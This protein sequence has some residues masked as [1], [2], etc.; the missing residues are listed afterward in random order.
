MDVVVTTPSG[1]AGA[2][3]G[4]Y[5]YGT[6]P[7]VT[8]ISPPT[9]PI[10]GGTSV[11]ITGLNFTGATS[12]TIGGSPAVIGTVAATTITA[13]TPAHAAGQADV[14][15]TTPI[16]TGTGTKL[17]TYVS[18]LTITSTAAA[19]QKV[20]QTYS[21]QNTA[22][23]GAPGYTYAVT[24]T[25]PPGTSLSAATG[26]VFGIPTALGSFT[27]TITA[28]D[29]IGQTASVNVTA[30]ITG[31]VSQLAL[32]SSVNPSFLGQQ[33]TL[34]ATATP[35]SCTGTIT[36]TD[37]TT[38]T[39][40]C[41]A[42]PIVSGFATCTVKFTTP[43]AHQIQA[44]Y[45]GSAQCLAS[46]SPVLVQTVNDQTIKTTQTIGNF[47][48][49]RNDLIMSSEPDLNRQVDRLA[50]ADGEFVGSTPPGAPAFAGVAARLGGGPDA[51]DLSRMRFGLRDRPGAALPDSFSSPTSGLG[52][53]G[54]DPSIGGGSVTAGPMRLTGN[55]D[56]GATRFSFSTSLREM[57]RYAAAAEASKAAEAGAGFAPGL[58]SIAAARFNPFDIWVEGKYTNFR[59]NSVINSATNAMDGQFGLISVGADYVLNRWLL[60][61][62]MAQFDIM[63]QTSHTQGTEASGQGWMLGPYATLRLSDH[64]FWQARGAWGQS[65]NEVNPFGTYSDH[66]ATQRWLA[67][68]TLL[69]RWGMGPWQ[70][71]PSVSVAYMEDVSQ[72]YADHFGIVIPSVKSQLGQAK[73]GPEIG[74]RYQFGPDLMI[75]PHVGMQVIYNFAGANVG[76]IAG[77]NAGPEGVRGRI[78]IGQRATTSRG[79]AV[80]MSGSYDGIGSKGYEAYTAKAQVHLPLQ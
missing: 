71:R 8:A 67:S 49:R 29:S 78:E 30:N 13:T 65:S 46:V 72:S 9:G 73:A 80:E 60:V 66:F 61:G 52:I 14:V 75:E 36:F 17:Y 47:M 18:L 54:S 63:T 79:I 35:N 57:A 51:Q 45:P 15:V 12:V 69:G 50:E 40:L 44:T 32:A 34:T 27:Y 53:P 43:G 19:T 64:V 16:G 22:S 37:L 20:G 10:A 56:D 26:L 1:S 76:V 3:N 59:D 38:A 58:G 5:T 7:I 11:T 77:Q 41:N 31:I 62:V 33:T 21:Q 70:F 74:Y 2:G 68:S 4:L 24:G 48:S 23:G 6:V 55:A 25:L 42:V 28:T 39:V